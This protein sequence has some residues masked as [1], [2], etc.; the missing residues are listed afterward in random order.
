MSKF[1]LEIDY[2]AADSIVIQSLKEQYNNLTDDLER[3][4]DDK[5]TWGIF[6]SDKEEDIVELQRHLDSIKTV[7]SYNMTYQDF[8]EWMKINPM[9]KG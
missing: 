6:S 8:E 9:V 3:R 5:E 4:K 2:D 7:L 1:T